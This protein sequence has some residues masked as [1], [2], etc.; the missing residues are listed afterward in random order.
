MFKKY[1]CFFF[2]TG[3]QFLLGS[4]SLILGRQILPTILVTSLTALML[5]L[6]ILDLV[7][8]R[9]H[10]PEWF[11]RQYFPFLVV[12]FVYCLIIQAGILILGPDIRSWDPLF[13]VIYIVFLLML[14]NLTPR[15]PYKSWM[16]VRGGWTEKSE[17]IW[18]RTHRL[19]GIV[20]ILFGVFFLLFLFIPVRI[21]S[22]GSL[23]L[24]FV[25]IPMGIIYGSGYLYGFFLSRKEK[26]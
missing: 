24:I 16:G 19:V 3:C 18:R 10:N 12:V 14:G 25:V 20:T 13:L 4:A 9:G 26:E 7:Y 21:K 2:M 23:I 5:F 17:W 6:T 1:K 11:D 22:M 15:V 8:R